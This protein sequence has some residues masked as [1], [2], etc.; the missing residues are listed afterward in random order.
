ME[1]DLTDLDRVKELICRMYKGL[2][3]NYF[4]L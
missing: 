1:A 3:S 4:S 2:K